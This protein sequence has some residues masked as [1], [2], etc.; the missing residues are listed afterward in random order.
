MT[1]QKSKSYRSQRLFFKNRKKEKER[2]NEKE[3]SKERKKEARSS[4]VTVPNVCF[5]KAKNETREKKARRNKS[6]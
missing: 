6:S 3:T 4:A 5:S 2:E 1:K